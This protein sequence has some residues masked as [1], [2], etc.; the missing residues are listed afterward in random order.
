MKK[1]VKMKRS[2]NELLKVVLANPVSFKTPSHAR[3]LCHWVDILYFKGVV[4][5][6]EQAVL[7]NYIRKNRPSK[8]S[9]L[10]AYMYENTFYYWKPG[11][12]RHRI[13][14]LK[15]HIKLTA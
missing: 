8:Y 12:R 7:A 13:K 4:C 1:E 14:W 2:I 15:K 6:E 3:G 9:S 11:V 5:Y 10:S